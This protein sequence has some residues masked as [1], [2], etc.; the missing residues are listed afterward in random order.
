[1]CERKLKRVRGGKY[2]FEKCLRNIVLVVW[3]FYGFS[4]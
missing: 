4:F 1:M 2:D 3:D